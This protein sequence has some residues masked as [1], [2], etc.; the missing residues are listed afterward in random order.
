VLVND[1]D[2]ATITAG[3]DYP[4]YVLT[5]DAGP[6]WGRAG[7]LVGFTTQCSIDPPRFLVCLSKRN[8]TYRASAG[9]RVVAVHTLGAADRDLAELFGSHT[10]DDIDKFERCAWRPGPDGVPVL[11]R[12]PAWFAGEITGRTDLGDHEG[13][14]LAPTHVAG[15]S[16]EPLLM[17]SAVRDLDPGHRA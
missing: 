13:L 16:T 4:M 8:R 17:F 3:L 5:L 7:C 6:P 12:C 10:G 11:E 1:D 9:A 14:T 2:F 15:G